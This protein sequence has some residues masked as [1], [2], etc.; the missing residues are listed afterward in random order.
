MASIDKISF[1]KKFKNTD[2][3]IEWG[4]Y[5]S[6]H[7]LSNNWA[8]IGGTPLVYNEKNK[9]FIYIQ[10][11]NYPYCV[12]KRKGLY[13]VHLHNVMLREGA[14]VDGDQVG[15]CAIAINDD[16]IAN[17]G[18]PLFYN[19]Q[20]FSWTGAPHNIILQCGGFVTLNVGDTVAAY[21]SKSN[22]NNYNLYSE[23]K[24]YMQ[25]IHICDRE[26]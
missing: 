23:G 13:Y 2:E 1:N 5:G 12:I 26:E 15:H 19:S 6:T 22:T 21:L 3:L 25:I 18:T 16:Q 10:N 11:E 17:N 24:E 7:T 9:Y 14:Y 20:Y 8:N 4:Q